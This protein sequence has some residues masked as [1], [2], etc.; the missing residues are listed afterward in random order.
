MVLITTALYQEAEPL[1]RALHLK[2]DMTEKHFQT[3]TNIS[4]EVHV[5]EDYSNES[6]ESY[7]NASVRLI[8]TGPGMLPAAVAVTNA[9]SRM[10]NLDAVQLLSIGTCANIAGDDEDQPAFLHDLYQIVGIADSTTGQRFYPDLLFNYGLPEGMLVTGPVVLNDSGAELHAQ[11]PAFSLYDMEG[12]AIAKAASVFLGPHQET[13]LRVVTDAGHGDAVT[14]TLVRDAV[15]GKV[16]TFLQVVDNLRAISIKETLAGGKLPEFTLSM[17]DKF[18]HDAHM[19]V[20]M[21]NQLVQYLRYLSLS[22]QDIFTILQSY[23]DDGRLPTRDRREG[24]N[25]LEEIQKL[26]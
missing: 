5:S 21:K 23:Y 4:S 16:E 8:I 19:S 2:R 20:T 1:I 22:G 18:A 9:L 17:V 26:A 13:F 7:A 15:G 3:F 14:Q 24:K 6:A 10:E 25:V 12:A 11:Y